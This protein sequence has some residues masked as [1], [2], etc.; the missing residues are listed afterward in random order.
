MAFPKNFEILQ[1]C[2]SIP[3]EQQYAD[4]PLDRAPISC[5]ALP[6]T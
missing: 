2:V 4:F 5:L 1:F 3:T 6:G